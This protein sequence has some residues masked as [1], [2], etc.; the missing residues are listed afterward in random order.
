M[1]SPVS[2]PPPDNPP[3][4]PV[5]PPFLAAGF[6][7]EVRVWP[8]AQTGWTTI[9]WCASRSDAELLAEARME[10]SADPYCEVWGPSVRRP[11][12]HVALIRYDRDTP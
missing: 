12:S 4:A 9:G 3:A 11:D 1:A 7:Y 5:N 8:D 2:A 6:A 10:R